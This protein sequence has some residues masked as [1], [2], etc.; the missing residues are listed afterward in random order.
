MKLTAKSSK[1]NKLVKLSMLTLFRKSV[2]KCFLSTLT[3]RQSLK[4]LNGNSEIKV[5]KNYSNHF[6]TFW[7]NA[8]V[9]L[10]TNPLKKHVML[11][12]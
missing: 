8:S 5:T 9:E 3:K 11:A 4:L 10:Q 12:F 2:L 1:S 6:S 7:P